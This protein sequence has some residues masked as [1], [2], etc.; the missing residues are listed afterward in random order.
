MNNIKAK[1]N[2]DTA[3]VRRLLVLWGDKENY[4]NRKHAELR[5]YQQL[6][7]DMRDIDAHETIHVSSSHKSN[8]TQHKAIKVINSHGDYMQSVKIINDQIQERLSLCR[9]IDMAIN[10][11]E[12]HKQKILYLYYAKYRSK[13]QKA[14]ECVARASGYT[15]E[16][17][18]KIASRATSD[19]CKF[20][21]ADTPCHIVSAIL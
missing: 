19:L 18:R 15:P 1:Q 12:P 14:W 11:L 4:L 13:E 21:K 17:A 10:Q 8:P 20:V 9:S 7:N 3:D 5:S 6:L 2:Y 16:A